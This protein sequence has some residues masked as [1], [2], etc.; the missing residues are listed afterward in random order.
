MI[1]ATAVTDGTIELDGITLRELPKAQRQVLADAGLILTSYDGGIRAATGT[2]G[3][4]A[5]RARTGPH[6]G[7]P[8]DTA[9]QLA[10]LLT[11]ASYQ[12]RPDQVRPAHRVDVRIGKL[13]DERSGEG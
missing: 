7:R 12:D 4:R 10:A 11:Q 8:T 5:V 3:L 2:G 13:Q 1:M 6:P 9:P